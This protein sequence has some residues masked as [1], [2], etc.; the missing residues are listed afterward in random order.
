MM[1]VKR[2]QCCHTELLNKRI[3]MDGALQLSVN[4][5]LRTMSVVNALID[6]CVTRN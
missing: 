2:N 3:Q 6:E 4:V 5:V 1:F